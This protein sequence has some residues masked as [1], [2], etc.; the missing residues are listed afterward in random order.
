MRDLVLEKVWSDEFPNVCIQS[1]HTLR[2]NTDYSKK[3]VC[4]YF[5]APIFTLFRRTGSRS[6]T[7]VEGRLSARSYEG[8]T[9]LVLKNGVPIFGNK[10]GVCP[11]FSYEG[12]RPAAKQL[13]P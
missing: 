12:I 8:R 11:H 9:A 3:G 4:P 6:W 1:S 10:N 5:Y 13:L 7:K 2:F